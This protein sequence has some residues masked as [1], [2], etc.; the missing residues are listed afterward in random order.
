MS[1]TIKNN[2]STKR[3]RPAL[4][5]EARENQLIAKAINMAEEQLDNRTASSQVLCH[6]LKLG[7]V[8]AQLELERERKEIELIKAKASAMASN[9]RIEKLYAQAL[10]AMRTYAGIVEDT[11]EEELDDYDSEY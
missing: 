10:N 5:P 9:E 7:T 2:V 3:S 8:K 6:Y 4:T 1:K 11:H